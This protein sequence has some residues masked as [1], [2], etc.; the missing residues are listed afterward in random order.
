MK[1]LK[2]N[3]LLHAETKCTADPSPPEGDTGRGMC[4]A[5]AA[6][7]CYPPHDATLE[8]KV[9]SPALPNADREMQNSCAPRRVSP[10]FFFANV[11]IAEIV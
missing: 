2:S 11:T 1:R 4:A 3:W 8:K 6:A 9:A 5:A 7:H 10:T